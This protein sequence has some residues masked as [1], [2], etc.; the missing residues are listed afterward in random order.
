MK[1]HIKI[2]LY[3]EN[4]FCNALFERYG[5]DSVYSVA[6]DIFPSN[7]TEVELYEIMIKFSFQPRYLTNNNKESFDDRKLNFKRSQRQARK[8]AKKVTDMRYYTKAQAEL[9]KAMEDGKALHKKEK[10]IKTREEKQKQFIAKQ[11][12]LKEKRKGH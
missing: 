11:E 10:S 6:K 4:G 8:I 5:D 9:N 2:G 12:K 1:Y 7:I 3:F